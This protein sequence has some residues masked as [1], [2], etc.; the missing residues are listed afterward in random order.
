[1]LKKND[2]EQTILNIFEPF[3]KEFKTVYR[4]NTIF[5]VIFGVV[6]G[7]LWVASDNTRPISIDF[8]KLFLSILGF[9]CLFIF[10]SALSKGMMVN[11][12]M[13]KYNE[14]FPVGHK[15][16]TIADEIVP[17][18]DLPEFGG[19]LVNELKKAQGEST[20]TF[21]KEKGKND[22]NT[23]MFSCP[24]CRKNIRVQVPIN[25]SVGRC[26]NCHGQFIVE[27]DK[28]DNLYIFMVNEEDEARTYKPLDAD[29][30]FYIIGV[31]KTA[32]SK[33]IKA[34]YRQRMQE[35]HPDKVAKLGDELREL[36]EVK[37]KQINAAYNYLKKENFV[38]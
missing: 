9:S 28:S 7:G 2:I 21:K 13:K 29:Q 26:K 1:M 35:Y 5:A 37:A 4:R 11:N 10:I 31:H 16:R 24:S 30:C 23:R 33:Q 3:E 8:F 32:S 19:E 25:K 15:L 6:I 18:I 22:E 38:T 12:A 36:A 14:T 20:S 17:N 34:A 27:T